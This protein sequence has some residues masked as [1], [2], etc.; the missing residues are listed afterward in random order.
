VSDVTRL[1]LEFYRKQAKTLLKAARA[2][3]AAALQRLTLP[4]P[5]LNDAQRIIAHEQGFVSWPR[6]HAF[7]TESELDFQGLVDRFIDAAI[8]DGRRAWE[9]LKA[10]PEVARAGFY[11]WLVIGGAEAVGQAVAAYPQLINV[12]SGP[13]NI[14]PLVYA[15]FSR[16]GRPESP[17]ADRL[18]ETVCVLLAAGANPNCAYEGAHGRLSCLYAASSVLCNAEMTRLLLEAGADPNDGESLYHS[19]EEVSLTCMKLL[20]EHSARVTGSNALKHMLDREDSEGLRLLLAHEGDPDETNPEGDTA[21]HW[22]IRR[23]RSVA[24]IGQLLDAGANINA[25]RGDGRTPYALAVV[26][27]QTDIVDVLAARGADTRLSP[28]DAFVAGGGGGSRPEEASDPA[29][30][31]LLTQLAESGNLAAVKALLAAGVPA[32][33]AGDGGITALHYACWRGN[34]K[35]MR[36]LIAAGAP[37]D[38][39]DSMYGGTPPGFLHHGATHC[40]EGDYAEGAR[41]LIAAGVTEW[42]TPS[43]NTGMDTVLR[44]NNLI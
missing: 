19:T 5:A 12:K 32:S 24:I 27:G 38:I 10:H 4:E 31:R 3:D 7:I 20:L 44:E 33:S 41:L 28:V 1:N 37:L 2:G 11:A 29:N 40:D 9:M 43:G 18:V 36:L 6:F 8:S 13:Q 39:K 22:A 34:V 35:M 42:N 17:R 16:F 23:G 14:E 25:I 30:A 21:L 26:S 15:C